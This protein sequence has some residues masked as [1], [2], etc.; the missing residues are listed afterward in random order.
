[1]DDFFFEPGKQQ[2][3]PPLL[4]FIKTKKNPLYKTEGNTPAKP[5]RGKNKKKN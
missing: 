3:K 2:G 5:E 4:A 1:M